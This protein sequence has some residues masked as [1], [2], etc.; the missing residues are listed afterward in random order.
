MPEEGVDPAL[1]PDMAAIM[2]AMHH[3]REETNDLISQ[4]HAAHV[5]VQRQTY[6]FF[7]SLTLD[8]CFVLRNLFGQDGECPHANYKEGILI[9]IIWYKWKANPATGKTN[10]QEEQEAMALLSASGKD[11]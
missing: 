9:G 6:E 4:R 8:Q 3:M 2:H 1:P 10:A 5:D 7:D 11:N